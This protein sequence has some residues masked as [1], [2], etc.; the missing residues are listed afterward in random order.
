MDEPVITLE[1][2]SPT[3]R[4]VAEIVGLDKYLELVKCFGGCK[5][6]YIPKYSELLRPSRDVEITEKFNGYNY[7]ELAMEYDLSVR[8]IYKLV[9]HMI[10]ERKNAP[11]ENQTRLF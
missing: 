3:Q 8:T 11:M 10:R 5:G 1:N 6:I 4:E 9:S 2:L 7:D